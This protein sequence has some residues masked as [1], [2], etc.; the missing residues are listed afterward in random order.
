[1]L[2]EFCQQFFGPAAEP[3]KKLYSRAEEVWITG[4]H[5]GRNLHGSKQVAAIQQLMVQ[6]ML[7]FSPWDTLFTE[8]VLQ[9][10]V[11]YLEETEAAETDAPYRERV[12]LV[13][14]GFDWS[15]AEASKQ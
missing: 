7:A 14:K 8:D 9:E 6:G 1:M 15:L 3:M 13:R 2:D 4:D 11:D 5:G 10:L 12:A